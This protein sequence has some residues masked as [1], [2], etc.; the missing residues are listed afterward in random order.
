[1]KA[2]SIS[3]AQAFGLAVEVVRKPAALTID[4]DTEYT[5]GFSIP[6]SNYFYFHQYITN[7]GY[8][9]GGTYGR[10]S[11]PAGFTVDGVRIYSNDG[12]LQYYS[13]SEL[14]VTGDGYYRVAVGQSIY[15]NMRHVRWFIQANSN[16][17]CGVYNFNS[18]A[19]FTEGGTLYASNSDSDRVVACN[20]VFVP[21]AK[22]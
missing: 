2:Y 5:S 14:Y 16:V 10:L 13:A 15:G 4:G 6:R 22:R 21:W 9:T 8:A 12:T 1:M 17:P 11:V 19:Y 20:A 18:Q 3:T 7:S